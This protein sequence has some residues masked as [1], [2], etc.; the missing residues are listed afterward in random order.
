MAKYHIKKDGSPGICTAQEGACPLGGTNEHFNSPEEAQQHAD[1][2]NQKFNAEESLQEKKDHEIYEIDRMLNTGKSREELME[3]VTNAK[4]PSDP[5]YDRVRT[6]YVDKS[7]DKEVVVDI[8]KVLRDLEHPDAGATL[9]MDELRS[10]VRGFCYSPYPEVSKVID[11]TKTPSLYSEI[12]KYKL[13]NEELLN[14][15]NHYIGLWRSPHDGK[16]YLDVSIVSD[17]AEDCRVG[18]EENDQQAFFDLQ[19]F[20]SVEVDANATSGQG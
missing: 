8:E 20:S 6:A 5:K 1:K 4:N 3:F 12:A 16:L 9:N 2:L 13:E 7:I 15:D 17:S 14:K 19:V 10:P 11:T 18:C